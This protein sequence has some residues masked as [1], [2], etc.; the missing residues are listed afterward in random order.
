MKAQVR[1]IFYFIAVALLF[2]AC[3][4]DDANTDDVP[5][6]P[7]EITPPAY[8]F[9]RFDGNGLLMSKKVSVFYNDPLNGIIE[10]V[11]KEALASFKYSV[12]DTFYS[13]AGA[14]TCQ[15]KGLSS[16]PNKSYLLSGTA[17]NSLAFPDSFIIWNVAGN[18]LTGIA[19]FIY[20]T[21]DGMPEYKG[22]YN[23]SIPSDISKANGVK[24]PL[25]ANLVGADS[26]FISITSGA[27]SVHKTI[28]GKE[29]YREF[30][31][32]ELS[33]LPASADKSAL[34]Q[35][36]PIKFDVTLAGGQKMYFANQNSYS[37][38]ITIH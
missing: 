32:T 25:G 8:S 9:S 3:K 5:V 37:K 30:S 13:D 18:N 33:P 28:G 14:V 21:G 11:S 16:Q 12:F 34:L 24:I 15:G 26:V 35:V 1:Y 20:S 17:A 19:D 31:N 2:T 7:P 38:Y 29:S 36:A 22:V 23:N 6:T 10:T 27:K 4:K